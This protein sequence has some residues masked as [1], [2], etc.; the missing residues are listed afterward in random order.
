MVGIGGGG[1]LMVG[2][3]GGG[4]FVWVF[5]GGYLLVLSVWWWVY[6][7]GCLMVGIG[8]DGCLMVGIWWWV[9]NG[10][11]LMVMGVWWWVVV[12]GGVG[13]V[14]AMV[15][16]CFAMVNRWMGM[17]IE[18]KKGYG[19]ER[20]WIREGELNFFILFVGVVYI[21]LISCVGIW[22]RWPVLAH[23]C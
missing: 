14:V 21:I 18:K 5:D 6:G 17:G 22:D 1:C 8:G 10:W 2:I 19:E 4:Y 9:F 13:A 23:C 12:V 3:E 11:R 7:G 16:G 15:M 20:L